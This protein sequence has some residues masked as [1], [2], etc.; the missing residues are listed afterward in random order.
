LKGEIY[1]S[2]SSPWDL[3]EVQSGRA[4]ADT[5]SNR[6]EEKIRRVGFTSIAVMAISIV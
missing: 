4:K 1:G 5:E 2:V 3:R 6:G